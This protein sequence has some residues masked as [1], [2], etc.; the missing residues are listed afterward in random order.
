MLDRFSGNRRYFCQIWTNIT[1]PSLLLT[2]Q[3][4]FTHEMPRPSRLEVHSPPFCNFEQFF[5]QIRPKRAI[6]IIF[7]LDIWAESAFLL[8]FK[9]ICIHVKIWVNLL[10]IYN[11]NSNAQCIWMKKK[12]Y[13]AYVSSM[14][15]IISIYFRC[16]CCLWFA[17]IEFYRIFLYTRV[18]NCLHD[19]AFPYSLCEVGK[20][21]FRN[22][23]TGSISTRKNRSK[24][25]A[26]ERCGEVNVKLYIFWQFE[27]LQAKHWGKTTFI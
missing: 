16:V 19:F 23:C 12:C 7:Q 8:C 25:P 18:E 1:I 3:L 24:I 20:V 17:R 22:I 26:P 2:L 6:L 11:L 21:L 5:N 13:S 4:E 27:A 14:L 15:T 10:P 9:S